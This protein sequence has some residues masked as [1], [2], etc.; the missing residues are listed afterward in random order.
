MLA[1][2]KLDKRIIVLDRDGVINEDSAQY[3]KSPDEWVPVTGSI[4]AIAKLYHH[5]YRI[6]VITNQSGIAR[7]YYSIE[8]LHQIHRKMHDYVDRAGGK[9]EGILFCPHGPDDAC[10]CRKPKAGLFEQLQKIIHMSLEGVPAIGDSWRDLQAAQLV[11]AFPILVRT[12]KGTD[13]EHQHASALG[14]IPV[15]QNLAQVVDDFIVQK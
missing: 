11:C 1:P 2:V 10:D 13:T 4:E 15:Y 14:E 9:I 3:I 12:G 5:G 6:F 7:Q 8:V